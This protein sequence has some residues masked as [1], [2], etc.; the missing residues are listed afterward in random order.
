[1][2]SL[3][4]IRTEAGLV[5]LNYNQIQFTQQLIEAWSSQITG[6]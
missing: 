4:K 6:Y 3:L 5:L 1:M 2:I